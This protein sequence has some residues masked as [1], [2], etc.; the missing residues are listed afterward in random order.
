MDLHCRCIGLDRLP[1]AVLTRYPERSFEIFAWQLVHI[2]FINSLRSRDLVLY[3]WILK[4][5]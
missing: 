4:T 1:T 5:V 3:I 2:L